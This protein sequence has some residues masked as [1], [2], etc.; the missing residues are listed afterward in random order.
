MRS[1]C[2]TDR[3]KTD[4]SEMLITR[5]LRGLYCSFDDIVPRQRQFAT[6]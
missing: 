4:I 6:A 5:P 1:S 2:R 3:I